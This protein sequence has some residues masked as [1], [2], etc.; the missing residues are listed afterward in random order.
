M[1]STPGSQ[2]NINPEDGRSSGRNILVTKLWLKS[3]LNTE[4]YFV[5]CLYIASLDFTNWDIVN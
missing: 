2:T 4:V 1:E 3:L 5:D